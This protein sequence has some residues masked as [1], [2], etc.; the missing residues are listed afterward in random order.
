[1]PRQ[2]SAS[3]DSWLYRVGWLIVL[4]MAGVTALA[5][6]ALLLRELMRVAGLRP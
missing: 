1:M 4:W 6:V 3:S 2:T 5:V